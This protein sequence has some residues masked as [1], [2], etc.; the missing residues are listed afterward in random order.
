MWLAK[1][2]IRRPVLTVVSMIIV[3]VLGAVSLIGLNMDLIPDINPPVGAVVA[4]YSGAGPDEVLEKVTKPLEKSLGTLSGLKTIQTQTQEGLVLVLL[5]FSWSEDIDDKQ[6]DVLSRIN[7]VN[8]PSDVETPTFLKFD[9]SAF[10]IM[11]LSVT[12]GDDDDQLRQDVDDIVQKITNLSGV[13]SAD[14]SGLLERQIK[15]ELD[16]KKMDR[17]HLS[18]NDVKDVLEANNAAMPGGIVND[19]EDDLTTRVI[20]ELP[21]V[22]AVRDLPVT[23][24]PA[25]GDEVTLKDVASVKVATEDRTLITRTNEKPSV[26]MNVFKQSGANTADVASHVHDEIEQLEQDMDANIVTIFDQGKYIEQAVGSVSQSLIGGGILAMLVLFIFLRSIKSPL[27]IGVAI[28]FSVIVTFVLMFFADFSLNIMTLG[29][30]ALGVGMLVDNAIVVIENTYRHLHMGKPPKQAAAE[31]AGEVAAAITASTL[32]TLSVF[33]PIVFVSGIVGTIFR[34]FAFTISFSL[35]ASLA[36]ALTIVPVMAAYLLKK[37]R[38]NKEQL[39]Q[40]SDFYQ[41]YRQMVKWA[42]GHRKSVIALA[43]ILLLA[44]GAGMWSVG[45]E[46]L[47]TMD[48][49]TFITK[50]E[51]PA[52]TGLKKT[53]EVTAKIEKI[54]A[55]DDD[56]KDFQ[57]TIGTAEGESSLYG[58]SGRNIAQISVSAVDLDKRDRSTTEI[59]N[60]LRSEMEDVNK[61]A[62]ITL[63]EQSSFDAGGAPNTIEF[64]ISGDEDIL[65]ENMDDVTAKLQ[66]IKNVTEVTNSEV[67]KQPELQV[68]VNREK[69]RDN[70]LAPAQIVS[71]VSQATRGEVVTQVPDD[72]G[73]ELAVLLRF[74]QSV[75]E[76]PKALQDLRLDGGNDDVTLDDVAKVAVAEGPTTLTRHNLE[77]A[78]EYTVQF[79]DT[80]LGQIEQE[81]RSALDDLDLPDDLDVMFT[82]ATELLA[83]SMNDL[84]LAAGLSILLVF[85]VLAGQFESFKYP[86]VILFTIP[87]IVIGV[88]LALYATKTPVGV[89]VM[90][91]LI[92]LVGIVVNN[93]IVMVDYINRLKQDGLPT[94]D[95]IV[96][97]SAVRLRPILM[98]ALTTILGLIP[99]AIGIGEGTEIQQP[100]ALTVIGGLLSST[101]LTLVVIPVV[102]SWFDRET[103]YGYTYHPARR[104]RPLQGV[105]MNRYALPQG[106]DV[107]GRHHQ[108]EQQAKSLVERWEEV[109]QQSRV[110]EKSTT[111]TEEPTSP[112]EVSTAAETLYDEH[113]D[114]VSDEDAH[115]SRTFERRNTE[116]REASDITS[117]GDRGALSQEDMFDLMSHMLEVA[118]KL[119]TQENRSSGQ[120]SE[121]G[122]R[123]NDNSQE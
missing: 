6:N 78:V 55:N 13:A 88:A 82:G 24:D 21:D 87:L 86:F 64:L 38:K 14:A 119:P 94:Y 100:M 106:G 37:P 49:G 32:T 113:A 118:K 51:M 97:A 4:T 36:V 29:G 31:G 18:Q 60:D 71:A 9:P 50:V 98:T 120:N 101:L 10:P 121:E 66:D 65:Q 95:A 22:D 102:Y 56:V 96:E 26:N 89:T 77:R 15:V 43:L 104:P 1:G 59:M 57:T 27:M 115:S 58:D 81:V 54:L 12:N 16:P 70:G 23:V 69:A 68:T 48:E 20:G 105:E 46:F 5:E 80:A 39:R 117:T 75:K 111:G 44:G 30:L 61:E 42:L 112:R 103:R 53:D 17:W 34:E 63:T 35:L 73:K 52:G 74:D 83:D 109:V 62:E 2:A 11:Q 99:L 107:T 116:K 76:S 8:L 72:S 40:Q 123:R 25:N 33:L 110:R 45:S 122:D 7:R 84:M 85:L 91:G 67:A 28:P 41:G 92:V 90:I 108:H 3:L 93:A 47:P 114:H 19:G 79:K